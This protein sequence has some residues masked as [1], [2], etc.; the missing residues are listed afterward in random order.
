MESRPQLFQDIGNLRIKFPYAG[1]GEMFVGDLE[2]IIAIDFIELWRDLIE[3]K[4]DKF[5]PPVFIVIFARPIDRNARRHLF[6]GGEERTIERG[7]IQF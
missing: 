3:D 7:R 4:I 6:P 2:E 1:F 5:A